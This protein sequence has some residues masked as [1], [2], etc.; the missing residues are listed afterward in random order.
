M[1]HN[2]PLHLAA[3]LST[4]ACP[5][6]CDGRRYVVSLS[7]WRSPGGGLHRSIVLFGD[8]IGQSGPAGYLILILPPA[9]TGRSYD[10][11][12]CMGRGC[13]GDGMSCSCE[14]WCHAGNTSRAC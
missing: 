9:F 10:D 7:K 8:E 11:F 3:R 6:V 14:E 2:H 13:G 12:R 1:C 4:R 5:S